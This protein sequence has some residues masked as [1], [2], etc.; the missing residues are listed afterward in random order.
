MAETLEVRR[1]L[2][3]APLLEGLSDEVI[4]EFSGGSWIR[5]VDKGEI[6]FQQTDPARAVYLVQSGCITIYLSTVD[7]RELVI[8]E[9]VPGDCFGELSLI[10][11]Q[12]RSTSAMAREYSRL[13]VIPNDVFQSGLDKEPELL[14][15]ILM[16]TASRLRVSSERESAL[17][18]L[19]SSAR[20]AR[21]L[22]N[23]DQQAGENGTVTITQEEL[24]QHVGLTRQTVA[25]T[26][27]EWRGRGW[28]E[29]R[30]GKILILNDQALLEI[31]DALVSP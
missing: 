21:V 5:A 27:G 10:T 20:I 4:S 26:L 15:R 28:V 16:T 3:R 8:N 1:S 19:D 13:I 6:L 23:L 30:R 7:G 2:Q 24:A 31:S 22:L 29:T 14:T 9:M 11:G 18:F 25:K 17:A 12:P